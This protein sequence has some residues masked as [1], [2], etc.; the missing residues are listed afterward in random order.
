MEQQSEQISA[1][2]DLK[3]SEKNQFKGQDHPRTIYAK[4]YEGDCSTLVEFPGVDKF[5]PTAT[6]REH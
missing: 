2:K 6:G 4:N 1:S 5:P 3:R